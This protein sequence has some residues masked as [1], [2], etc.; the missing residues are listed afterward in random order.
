M[1]LVSTASIRTS[2]GNAFPA[3]VVADDPGA[4]GLDEVV[5]EAMGTGGRPDASAPSLHP[6][7]ER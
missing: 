4:E 2:P 6:R 7:Q 5:P 1:M 3:S